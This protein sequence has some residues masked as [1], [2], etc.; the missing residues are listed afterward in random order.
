M[1]S[2]NEQQEHLSPM[3]YGQGTGNDVPD[4]KQLETPEVRDELLRDIGGRDA[5]EGNLCYGTP[6]LGSANKLQNDRCS[7]LSKWFSVHLAPEALCHTPN[8][9][10][11]VFSIF[12][13]LLLLWGTAYTL[14]QDHVA[15]S[16]S[17]FI[18]FSLFILAYIAGRLIFFLKL[19][20]LLGMLLVGII[21]GN[22]NIFNMEGWYK[23]AVSTLRS[24]AMVIILIKAGLGLDAGALQRLSF[25]VIRLAFVPCLVEASVVACVSHFLLD[26]PWLWGALLGFV[27]GA[28]S[29]AVVVPSLL[30]LKD[31]GYGEDKGIATLVIA[32]SSIDDILAIS[33]FGVIL[34]TIFSE[35]DVLQRF[36]QG[37]LEVCI[38]LSFG[39]LWGIVAIYIPHRSESWVVTGRSLMVGLGGLFAVFGSQLAGYSGAGP[40]ASIV[41][42]FVA[43][44]G[45]KKQGWSATNNPVESVFTSMWQI[46]QPVLFGLIGTAI[47]LSTLEGHAVIYGIATL[48]V[49]LSIRLVTSFLIVSGGT[50]NLKEMFFVA[51]SWFP[52]ATVQQLVLWHLIWQRN[53][54]LM[55]LFLD[56]LH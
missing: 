18:L 52:K 50:L 40:L 37:P 48:C 30:A 38:G 15:P 6:Q 26:L 13:I 23:T 47:N 12:T 45:W 27:L 42:A 35:G 11:T 39:I 24:T 51:I 46:F 17:L 56:M 25:V 43:C 4:I 53:G 9:P 54:I 8:F 16:S 19:P 21:I 14:F 34:S 5:E 22:V 32:A 44:Y 36:L 31:Q 29:P 49:G 20:P 10:L 3:L 28:V 33:G 2:G 41:M 55:K 7:R 1:T